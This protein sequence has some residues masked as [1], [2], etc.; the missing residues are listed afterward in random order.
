V[1]IRSEDQEVDSR[2]GRM[3]VASTYY[4]VY[5]RTDFLKEGRKVIFVMVLSCDCLLKQSS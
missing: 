2:P 3:T 5:Q 4:N 1:V